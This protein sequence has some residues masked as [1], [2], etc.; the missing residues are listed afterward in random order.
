MLDVIAQ[1]TP[2]TD[3][4]YEAMTNQLLQ[5]MHALNALMEKNAHPDRADMERLKAETRALRE[6]GQ[7][8]QASVEAALDRLIQTKR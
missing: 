1:P 4:D 5:E 8:L 7:R 6:E 2:K 3:A